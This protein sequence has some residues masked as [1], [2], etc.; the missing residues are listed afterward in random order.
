MNGVTRTS[1]AQRTCPSTATSAAGSRS[2][3]ARCSATS[4]GSGIV[5]LSV[6][7]TSGAAAARQPA[8]RF[9]DRPGISP[10][11]P[12]HRVA[13]LA[14]RRVD[15]GRVGLGAVGDHQHLEA[16]RSGAS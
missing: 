9:A 15:R 2:C 16:A 12:P 10:A 7:S 11:Q 1:R 8:L 6:N 4:R 5:S 13:A 14:D 3:Q